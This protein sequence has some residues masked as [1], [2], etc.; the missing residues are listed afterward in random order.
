[1]PKV[2]KVTRLVRLLRDNLRRGRFCH[3]TRYTLNNH[4][5]YFAL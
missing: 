5:S 2:A 4:K 3:C 1:L